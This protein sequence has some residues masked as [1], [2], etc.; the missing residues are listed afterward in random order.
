MRRSRVIATAA[1]AVLVALV[2]TGILAVVGV[3]DWPANWWPADSST[4]TGASTPSASATDPSATDPSA[5][6][7][8]ATEPPAGLALPSAGALTPVLPAADGPAPDPDAVR[9]ALAPLLREADLRRHTGV[10]VRDLMGDREV[11]RVGDD[12]PFVPA[13]T[14]KLL[15]SAAVLSELGPDN[16]FVTTVVRAAGRPGAT[17]TA[18]LV[19]G[20]DPLLATST[21]S[22]ELRGYPPGATI[23]ALA[24]QT[25]RNLRANGV[26]T[27]RVGFDETL[28]A[29]RSEAASWEPSYVADAVVS[30]ISALLLDGGQL[31]AGGPGPARAAADALV[32]AL[33][34]R[35]VDVVGGAPRATRTLGDAEVL[36]QAASPALADIVE[37]VLQVSDNEGAE[38][39]LRHVGLAT[40][41]PGSFGGGVAG[42][43]EVLSQLGVPF[44][45][46]TMYDGSGLSRGNRV[47]LAALGQ[48]LQL[49]ADA[50]HPELRTITAGL[51]VA[52]FSGSLAE[53]FVDPRT[54]AGRGVVR[55]KTGTLSQVQSLAG[56][57]VTRDGTLLGFAVLTDRIRLADNLDARQRIEEVAAVLAACGC[58][59]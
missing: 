43:R 12:D 26:R 24:G 55:A 54:A 53:R 32:Q 58:H 13:S 9:A 19:G 15:T 50:Q 25:A 35:G 44:G 38:V 10:L 29:G 18:V 42:V 47:S 49:G 30:P 1:L 5:T 51:P 17:P 4:P 11:L 23:A 2:A 16:R 22:A 6:D 48:V 33:R 8:A 56:T 20:G 14:L 46:I 45:A 3:L 57:V 31:G 52:R 37:Y 40:A 41:R 59:G 28:F 39:L 21:E 34:A 36:A 7:P 27:A